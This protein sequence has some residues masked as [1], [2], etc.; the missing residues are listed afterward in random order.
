MGFL[1]LKCNK[2]PAHPDTSQHRVLF[3]TH[4][5]RRII[6]DVRRSGVLASIYNHRSDLMSS[7][8]ILNKSTYCEKLCFMC[9]YN[10]H[11][12]AV[13]DHWLMTL[14]ISSIHIMLIYTRYCKIAAWIFSYLM[15]RLDFFLCVDMWP[16]GVISIIDIYT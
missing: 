4:L 15:S 7:C 10:I 11:T 5:W 8:D 2:S 13:S 3:F 9:S 1:S 16:M 6:S 12:F 14:Y